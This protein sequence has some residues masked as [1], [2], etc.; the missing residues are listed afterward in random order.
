MDPR[1]ASLEALLTGPKLIEGMG[2]GPC[3][4]HNA[5]RIIGVPLEEKP[6]FYQ[7]IGDN[8]LWIEPPWPFLHERPLAGC[9]DLGALRQ[10]LREAIATAE[11]LPFQS[12]H[13]PE[14]SHAA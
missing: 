7:W 8:D 11:P 12:I 3:R 13:I 4:G 10:R 1:I 5:A 14:L 2:D 9:I 6:A